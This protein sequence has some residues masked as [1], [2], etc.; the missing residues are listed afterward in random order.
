MMVLNIVLAGDFDCERRPWPDKVF[1][2]DQVTR[3]AKKQNAA[4]AGVQEHVVEGRLFFFVAHGT[5]SIST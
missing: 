2:L 1:T 4:Y 5:I 3:R